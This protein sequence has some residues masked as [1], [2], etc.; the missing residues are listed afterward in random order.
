[1]STDKT[2]GSAFPVN[3]TNEPNPGAYAADPG[4]TLW[5][6][7]AAAIATGI[8]ASD[9]HKELR[10][11]SVDFAGSVATFADAMIAERAKRFNDEAS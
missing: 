11:S 8:F 5:D 4:M 1:M 7:Y 2:G 3:T 10:P 9:L 6:Y